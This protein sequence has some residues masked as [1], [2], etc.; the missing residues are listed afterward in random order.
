[1]QSQICLSACVL[2]LVSTGCATKLQEAPASDVVLEDALPE[3]NIAAGWVAPTGDTQRVDDDWLKTFNDAQLEEL[4]DEALDVQNP[5]LRVLAAQ[6][7]RARAATALA[8]SALKPFFG[9]ASGLS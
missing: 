2:A 8:G 6:V 4:V 3:T 1:M 5:N 7:D 9:L